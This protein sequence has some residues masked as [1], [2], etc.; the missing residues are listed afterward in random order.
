VITHSRWRVWGNRSKGWTADDRVAGRQESPQVAHLRGRVAAHVDDRARPEGE[1]LP[2]GT[3]RRIP[4]LGGSITTAVSF[5]REV[6]P[7]EDRGGVPAVNAAF[8]IPLAAAFS[9]ANATDDSLTSTPAT[10]SK[11]PAEASAK[12]PLPQ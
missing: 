8:D 4:F 10:R 9:R 5:A 1:Q 3:P 12:R 11:A 6:E 7:R 2:R